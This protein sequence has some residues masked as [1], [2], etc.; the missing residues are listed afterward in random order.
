VNAQ[1]ADAYSIAAFAGSYYSTSS[2]QIYTNSFLT[3]GGEV[4]NGRTIR[5]NLLY[6]NQVA[7]GDYLSSDYAQFKQAMYNFQIG[8]KGK[9]Q[10]DFSIA[11]I[12]N[13]SW[14]YSYNKFN[15]PITIKY[16]YQLF[17]DKYYFQV[18]PIAS[19]IYTKQYNW[20]NKT[21][22]EMSGYDV[23]IPISKKIGKHFSFRYNIGLMQ[24][25]N[26]VY[27]LDY[28]RGGVFLSEKRNPK[29]LKNGLNITYNI[30]NKWLF[31][32]EAEHR[33]FN[34]YYF[35]SNQIF[36]SQAGTKWQRNIGVTYVSNIK[37]SELIYSLSVPQFLNKNQMGLI[38]GIAF[39]HKY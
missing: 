11:Y 2:N 7:F 34:Q 28:Y 37:K 8:I 1:Q 33:N 14:F 15:L 18:A 21:L 24:F 39:Q 12:K 3:S 13:E 4:L 9:H 31:F 5:H 29:M 10:I 36:Q 22:N 25:F 38:L 30:K 17:N 27:S 35:D 20:M 23:T 19:F 16:H 26:N 32:A 6:S